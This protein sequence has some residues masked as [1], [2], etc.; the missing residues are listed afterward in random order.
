MSNLN[1]HPPQPRVFQKHQFRGKGARVRYRRGMLA[2]LGGIGSRRIEAG[3]PSEDGE[4]ASQLWDFYTPRNERS[5][6]ARLFVS[7][8]EHSV[9]P[10]FSLFIP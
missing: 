2:R 10:F 1:S 5:M 4:G 3:L 9:E 7:V 6:G 8:L